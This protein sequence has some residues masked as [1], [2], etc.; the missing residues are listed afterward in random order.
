MLARKS[1]G[2]AK[3]NAVWHS[4]RGDATELDAKAPA[5]PKT[6]G[7]ANTR[8]SDQEAPAGAPGRGEPEAAP[9]R[10]DKVAPKRIRGH[11]PAFVAP[12]LAK[13][14]DRPPGG[15]RVGTRVETRRLPSAVTRGG[16]SRH[17]EDSQGPRLDRQIPEVAKIAATLPDCMIDGEVC[18]LNDQGVPDFAALQGA[19]ADE[20]TKKLVFFAFDVLFIEHE[21]LRGLPLT[22]RKERLKELLESQPAKTTHSIR[23]LEHFVTDGDAVLKSACEID[24]E[25]IVSKQ[26]AASYSSTRNGNWLKSKCR[27]GHEVVIGGWASEQG[28]LRSLIVGVYR[29]KEFVP[30]G[31]VGTGFGR[32]KVSSLMKRLG[33]SHPRRALFEARSQCPADGTSTG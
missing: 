8:R 22:D 25:G 19:L 12:Q 6:P 1:A 16:G 29:G 3:A 20:D 17:A 2:K 33:R 13:L 31:R 26:L 30:V 18:A 23:Y 15:D 21:D 28:K 9:S 4:N 5:S 10:K 7:N 27:A 32:D 14:V 24:M 11:I